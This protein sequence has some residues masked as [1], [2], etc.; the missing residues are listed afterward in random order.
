MRMQATEIGGIAVI[1]NIAAPRL[2]VIEVR[3]IAIT[4]VCAPFFCC[5]TLILRGVVLR[6]PGV[7]LRTRIL[8]PALQG[9]DGEGNR[10]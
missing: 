7:S 8:R 3:I 1:P 9:T 10:A 6:K 5:F 2:I 4:I